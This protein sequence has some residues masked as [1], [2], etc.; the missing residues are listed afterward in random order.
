MPYMCRTLKGGSR[1]VS[2]SGRLP[3]NSR[4]ATCCRYRCS[5]GCGQNIGNT[6]HITIKR[7]CKSTGYPRVTPTWR[8]SADPESPRPPT[9]EWSP[10]GSSWGWVVTDPATSVDTDPDSLMDTT[11]SP[12]EVIDVGVV[13]AT[14]A[15]SPCSTSSSSTSLY[16][17][18]SSKVSC[19]YYR[20]TSKTDSK[21]SK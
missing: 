8:E 16:S 17:L 14:E 3:R 21:S 11:C 15:E 4:L 2:D 9:G 19:H 12:T 10:S 13:V 18:R 7:V 20:L 5:I 1:R 6:S